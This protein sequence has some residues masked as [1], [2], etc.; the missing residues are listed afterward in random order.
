MRRAYCLPK[1]RSVSS[2]QEI[3]KKLL[4]IVPNVM[5]S[6][7]SGMRQLANPDLTVPQFRV[8]AHLFRD[9][10]LTTELAELQGVTVP[11]MSS[12]VDGLVKRGLI[13]RSHSLKDRRQIELQLTDQGR[14]VIT[15]L[16]RGMQG[17][18]STSLKK[19][20][21]QQLRTLLAGLQVLEQIF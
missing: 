14:R 16:R 15:Q 13:E 20:N 2:E 9:A 17:K 5:W 3:A 1:G 19:V 12:I 18:L 21:N 4:D 8:L 6:I 7:R 10:K 11:A